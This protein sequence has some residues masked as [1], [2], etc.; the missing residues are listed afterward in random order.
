[1][2]RI[3]ELT[4]KTP[5]FTQVLFFPQLF[6]E[7]ISFEELVILVTLFFFIFNFLFLGG[8]GAEREFQAS[9]TP[10]AELDIGLRLTTVTS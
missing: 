6:S 1:M 8:G 4:F 2:F 7:S 5:T 10:S 9:S 3:L